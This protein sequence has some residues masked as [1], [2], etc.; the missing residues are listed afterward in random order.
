MSVGS[1]GKETGTGRKKEKGNEKRVEKEEETAL[2]KLRRKKHDY[3]KR[4]VLFFIIVYSNI[5]TLLNILF[6]NN[7]AYFV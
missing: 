7:L 2:E 1:F 5:F 4:P 3:A 6:F